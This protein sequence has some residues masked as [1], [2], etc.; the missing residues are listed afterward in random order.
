MLGRTHEVA[1]VGALT[2]VALLHPVSITSETAVV[3]I[4]AALVGGVTPDLDKPGTK[5]WDTIPTGGLLSRVVHP[6]FIGGHRHITHSVLGLA[7]F[8]FAVRA[9]LGVLPFGSKVDTAIVFYSFIIAFI[10][11]LFMDM[12]TKEGIPALFPLPFHIGFPP[13]EFLR[14]K[15][16]SFAEKL[17]VTPGIVVIVAY[18]GYVHQDNAAA[19]LRIILPGN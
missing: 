2:L 12:L 3:S 1:A 9:L 14:V 10:S 8:G 5:L 6:I 18:T 16:N 4:L 11:H 15:T 17:I 13:F 7:L 19:L